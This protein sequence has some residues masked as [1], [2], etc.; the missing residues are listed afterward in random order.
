MTDKMNKIKSNSSVSSSKVAKIVIPV[1]V[2][3][4]LLFIGG[5][6][7]LVM[8]DDSGKKDRMRTLTLLNPPPPRKIKEKP[9]EPEIK[10]EEII[11][12]VPEPETPDEMDNAP[13]D[14]SQSVDDLLGLDSDATG[15]DSFGLKAKKG[16]HSILGNGDAQFRWYT[17][18]IQKEISETV[19][20]Y[21]EDNGGLPETEL[22]ALVKVEIDDDGRVIDYKLLRSSGDRRM[23]QAIMTALASAEVH[24]MPPLDMPRALKF[25]ITSK[26]KTS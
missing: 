20:K 11:E 17:S 2:L 25:R 15:S 14:E 5:V 24:E 13:E 26:G 18:M 12:Q 19:R 6:V 21:L 16:G 3:L 1:I 7:M 8:S 10:K 4:A 23:D 9:S 22:K